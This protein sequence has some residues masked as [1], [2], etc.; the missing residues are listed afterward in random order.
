[1]ALG[2]KAA[3]ERVLFTPDPYFATILRS[4]D[5][6][7]YARRRLT[8]IGPA[9][10]VEFGPKGE[11]RGTFVATAADRPYSGLRLDATGPL[12]ERGFVWRGGCRVLTARR[13]FMGG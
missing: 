3:G 7:L 10:R 1:M 12:Y 5:A 9:Y 2:A 6:F 11:V 13:P 4:A 8:K